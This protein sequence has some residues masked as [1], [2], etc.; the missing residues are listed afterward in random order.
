MLVTA[1]S[2]QDRDAA[3]PLLWNLHKAFPTIK[4]T[5][6]DGGYAGKLVTWAKTQFHLTLQIVKRPEDLHGFAQNQIWCELVGMASE[7]TAWMQLLALDG[8]ARAWEPRRLRLRPFS[9]ALGSSAA[10]AA[11]GCASP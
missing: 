9:A 2:V 3:K 7:L 10:A 11:C 5:R 6:A 1:V 4:L 8:P